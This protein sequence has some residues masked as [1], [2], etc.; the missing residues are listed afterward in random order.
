VN[1]Q[2]SPTEVLAGIGLKLGVIA[3]CVLGIMQHSVDISEGFMDSIFM[4][5][6]TES[7]IW[8]AAMCFV[9]LCIDLVTKGR[10]GVPQW[11]YAVKYM[12]TTSVILTWLAFAVLLSPTMNVGYLV[13]PSNILLHNVTPMLAVL[14]FILFDGN[15]DPPRKPSSFALVMP[16]AYGLFFFAA[17][18]LSGRLPVP[19]F[20]LD[21][22]TYGWLRVD[23]RGI[24]V[25]YW[26]LV[27][28]AVLLGIGGGI[29]NLKK[30]CHEKPLTCSMLVLAAM[31]G[32]SLVFALI[33][34]L[35]PR[36]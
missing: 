20:F 36:V 19:Y 33:S 13:S 17:Y 7:N 18:E 6:T 15:Y 11:L 25:V 30:R 28:S 31:P 35:R 34:V 4:A 24:G 16:L 8:V 27:L 29:L 3:S 12:T 23:A 5:F 2:P 26:I 10:R 21:Y 22:K 14:D 1:H 32:L 9:F